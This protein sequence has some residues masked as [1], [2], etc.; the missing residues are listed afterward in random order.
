[1]Q[2]LQLFLGWYCYFALWS[3]KTCLPGKPSMDPI[4]VILRQE[5]SAETSTAPILK[6]DV[7]LS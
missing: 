3:A 6:L 1:M 2:A 5:V 7:N 4:T